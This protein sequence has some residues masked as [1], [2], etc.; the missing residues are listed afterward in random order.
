MGVGGSSV[1]EGSIIFSQQFFLR[2]SG[3]ANMPLPNASQACSGVAAVLRRRKPR[4]NKNRNNKPPWEKSRKKPVKREDESEPESLSEEDYSD[5]QEERKEEYRKGGYHPVAEGE[6]YNNR[7]RT[8]YKLGWGYFSTVWLVWDYVD[9]D[10]KAMKV[11]KGADHYRDAAFDEIKL[12]NQ[13]MRGDPKSEKCCC[14]MTDSFEHKGPNG[15]HVVMVFKVLG[16]NL[17]SLITK[18][19]YKGAPIRLIKPI[20]KQMLIGLDY[21]HRELSII[22]TDIK[23]ENVLLATPIK[24]IRRI[25]EIYKAPPIDKQL[26]LTEKDPAHLSKAQKKRLKKKMKD[27]EKKGDESAPPPADEISAKPVKL[28]DGDVSDEDPEFEQ[29]RRGNVVLADFGNG[30]WIDKQF[31]EE[32]QTRQYRSPEVILGDGYSTPIDVWS[33]ACVIFELLTG[34]FLFDPR[35]GDNFDRDEDHLALMIELLG[36]LPPRISRGD[37]KHR[38]KYLT[39]YGELRHITEYVLR[40]VYAF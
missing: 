24:K 16:E 37:G 23:P 26:L 15:K 4:K 11:Q 1:I 21:L 38:D 33:C 32:V 6:L 40:F 3:K 17:L 25:M 7:Y 27:K 30:C 10:F 8:A 34:E 39:K 2:P 22:H 29:A 20:A 31:S 28:D 35:T 14:S 13:I 9:E 36:P 18:Y 19:E 12:L 5:T